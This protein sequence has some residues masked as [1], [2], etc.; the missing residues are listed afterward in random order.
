MYGQL[1]PVFTEEGRRRG[2]KVPEPPGL[3]EAFMEAVLKPPRDFATRQLGKGNESYRKDVQKLDQGNLLMALGYW[4]SKPSEM[5]E[6]RR[7]YKDINV[8]LRPE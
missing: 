5:M 6:T 4:V 7:R 2:G 1:Q 3:L 8:V